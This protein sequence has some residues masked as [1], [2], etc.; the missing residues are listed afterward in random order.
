[1]LP[2]S[3]INFLRTYLD[4][5]TQKRFDYANQHLDPSQV[6]VRMFWNVIE[7][8][9]ILGITTTPYVDLQH[10]FVVF[11][12][13]IRQHKFP[14]PVVLV[15]NG[16]QEHE[17]AFA[18]EAS[19]IVST[20]VEL[21]R[22]TRMTMVSD[23]DFS[24]TPPSSPPTADSPMTELWNARRRCSKF[25]IGDSPEQRPRANRDVHDVVTAQYQIALNSPY[26]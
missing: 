12:A 4:D 13:A 9:T 24:S 1:M 6:D 7:S 16:I 14:D 18:A 8:D 11:S 21:I 22:S 5:A 19:H 15:R 20:Q 26:G 23:N 25:V 3:L 17:C 2:T 10:W